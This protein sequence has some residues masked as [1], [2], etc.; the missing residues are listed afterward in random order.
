MKPSIN[1]LVACLSRKKDGYNFAEDTESGWK[2]YMDK[3]ASPYELFDQIDVR[4]NI[5]PW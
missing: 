2:S 3:S 1:V 4:Y 5:I